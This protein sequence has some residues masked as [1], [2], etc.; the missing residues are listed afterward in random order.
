MHDELHGA[1]RD[2]ATMAAA[3]AGDP[4]TTSDDWFSLGVR[5]RDACRRLG[6]ATHVLR[7]WSEPDDGRADIDDL[8]AP[9]VDGLAPDRLARLRAA[10]AGRRNTALWRAH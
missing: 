7:E 1:L 2:A 9:Q 6:S 8:D 3:A 5:L 10:R 4:R